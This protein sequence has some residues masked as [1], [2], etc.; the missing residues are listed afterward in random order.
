VF[1]RFMCACAALFAVYRLW[2]CRRVSGR[3]WII[4]HALLYAWGGISL[5]FSLT[6][7]VLYLLVSDEL[8]RELFRMWSIIGAGSVGITWSIAYVISKRTPV[9]GAPK[10]RLAMLIFVIV[11]STAL[12]L[13]SEYTSLNWL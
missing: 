11:S 9:A 4:L 7:A 1:L 6:N 2:T 8:G 3:L 13:I 5:S 12:F 10:S